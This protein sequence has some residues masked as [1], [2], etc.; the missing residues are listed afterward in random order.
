MRKKQKPSLAKKSVGVFHDTPD[1]HSKRVSLERMFWLSALCVLLIDQLSKLWV[2]SALELDTPVPVLPPYFYLTL[3]H[4]TGIAFGLLSGRGWLTIP[5]T[6]GVVAGLIWYERR[7]RP[8]RSVRLLMGILLG[9]ALGNFIDRVRLG[10]VVDM[11]DF[12]VWP[13]F[14][15]ADMAITGSLLGLI[16]LQMFA[17]AHHESAKD[18]KP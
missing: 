10:Y 15:V 14:N 17:P 11:F 6:L 3:T 12:V 16:A 13:V 18:V 8:P 5:L 2:V 1:P 4:N 9:G 7:A